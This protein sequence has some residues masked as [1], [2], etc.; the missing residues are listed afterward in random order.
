MKNVILK[1][2]VFLLMIT[3]SITVYGWG[4]KGHDV[5]CN[6]A[7]RHLSKKA[8]K[9]I[10]NLLDG[11]SIVYWSNW[12][13]NA[14]HTPEYA[15]TSTWHY[16]NIDADQTFDSQPRNSFGDVVTAIT[17]QIE[18]LKDKNRSRDEKVLALKF[19][20]HLV[21][22]LHC[23]MHMGHLSDRGGNRWQV[24]FFDKGTNL[25]SIFDSD[26]V[27]SAHKW[28]FTEWT[29]ELDIL[30]PAEQSLVTAGN[31]ETWARETHAITTRLYE[32]TPVG[33][34]LSFNYIYEWTE[35]IE[36]QFL[37]GGLRLAKVLNEIFK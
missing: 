17:A 12:M 36:Q 22:D 26:M 18:L 3:S 7:Q 5:T 27:E 4:Q 2:F 13:D 34:K 15:Y 25:H 30:S 23:P 28:T 29:N 20:V 37:R 1:S 21:G 19:L 33:S 16:L 10:A 6:I 32:A 24:Q 8:K 14:S 11:R 31:I 9:Q 35:T